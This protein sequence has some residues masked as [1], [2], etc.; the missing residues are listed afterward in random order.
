[1]VTFKSRETILGELRQFLKQY[2]RSIDT[3]D[4][5]LAKDF[6]LLPQAVGGSLVFDSLDAVNDSFILAQQTSDQLDLEAQENFGIQRSSGEYAIVTVTFYSVNAPTENISISA[7]TQVQTAGT[8][9]VSPVSFETISSYSVNLSS[10]SSF[11]SYDRG[12]YEFP[13]ACRATTVGSNGNVGA[14]TIQSIIGTVSQ[15][16]GCTN[17]TASSGGSDAES[18]EDLRQ[19]INNKKTGRDLNTR[20]GTAAFVTSQSFT[21]AY[22]VRVEDEDSERASGVDVFVIDYYLSSVTESFTY[23]PEIPRYYFSNL[24]IESVSSVVANG[25]PLATTTYD[26]TRDTT[27]PLRRS[28]LA[29]EY[30]S[31][32][33]SASLS[34]GTI[35]TVTYT[36]RADIS[37]LQDTFGLNENDV[38][39]ADVLVKR[40]Y[41]LLLN[42]NATLTLKANADGPATRSR[43]RNALIQFMSTYRL[44]DNVQKSD[45]IL[46][47]QQGYGD[48]SVDSV[49][50]VIINSYSLVDEQGTVQ[51]PV[52]ETLTVA[53]KEHAIAGTFTI[54]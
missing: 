20:N 11:F 14:G 40:A 23:Y 42:L 51:L 13:V 54:L 32:R 7:G 21:D 10:I 46:V 22:P 35:F 19:R 48:F 28:A 47:L 33:N 37:Q 44:G 45:L 26:V 1:M 31:I 53:N 25:S 34:S 41:P 6:V 24:P 36:Y 29:Q 15:I 3:G 52:D 43:V 16:D 2:N 4:N 49:D 38:L 18:D 9:F 8:S 12:R 27:T 39:T 5:S 17:L 50:A 30:I